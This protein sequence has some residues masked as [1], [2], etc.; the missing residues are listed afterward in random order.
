M[1]E[2]VPVKT[3]S[4]RLGGSFIQ[5]RAERLLLLRSA[6][7]F[8]GGLIDQRRQSENNNRAGRT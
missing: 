8:F 3:C 7:F 1:A 4:P 5:F 2:L 6:S